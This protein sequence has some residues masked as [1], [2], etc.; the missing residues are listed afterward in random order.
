MTCGRPLTVEVAYLNKASSS[1][2]K[3]GRNFLLAHLGGVELFFHHHPLRLLCSVS[4]KLTKSNYLLWHAQV[5]PAICVA[6]LEG[7][8]T[9]GDNGHQQG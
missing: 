7:F 4:E 9:G 6:E 8:F 2:S 1:T 3:F 5:M